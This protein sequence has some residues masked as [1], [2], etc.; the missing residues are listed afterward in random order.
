MDAL[1]FDP[2][3]K[4]KSQSPF[5]CLATLNLA[6]ILTI[7]K[8]KN[9][10]WSPFPALLSHLFDQVGSHPALL[11]KPNEHHCN[12]TLGG[13]HRICAE[14]PKHISFRFLLVPVTYFVT[15]IVFKLFFLKD[16]R[17]LI[18]IA[19][20]RFCF[21]LNSIYM[22]LSCILGCHQL[23]TTMKAI[24]VNIFMFL[25]INLCDRSLG[26]IPRSGI[27]IAYPLCIF[28]SLFLHLQE[29]FVYV[30]Y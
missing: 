8:T 22:L 25:L 28:I 16:T 2:D 24:E 17:T 12:Q 9:F 15:Y 26:Y 4:F 3:G 18:A 1:S 11:R 21:L 7:T 10:N 5:P 14:W 30:K 20:L 29:L 19:T 13:T 6:C 27:T 23:F